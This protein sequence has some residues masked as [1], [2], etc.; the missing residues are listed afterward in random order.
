MSGC[1]S[2]ISMFVSCKSVSCEPSNFRILSWD[3]RNLWVDESV[4][5]LL[6]PTYYCQHVFSYML[7]PTYFCAHIVAHILL[8]TCCFLHVIAHILL[9]T[10]FCPHIVTQIWLPTY[11]GP[12]IVAHILFQVHKWDSV[13]AFMWTYNWE[14][15]NGENLQISKIET[16]ILNNSC[17]E[18][19]GKLPG[20]NT[21]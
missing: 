18:N 14:K 10:Y 1:E 11:C 3:S 21:W 20:K 19:F 13:K 15:I 4:S 9:P 7:L 8:P 16:G 6:L 5:C 2:A 17:S 12:H